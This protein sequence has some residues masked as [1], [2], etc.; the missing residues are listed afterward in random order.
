MYIA[1]ATINFVDFVVFCCG[2]AENLL[3]INSNNKKYVDYFVL[4]LQKGE[5]GTAPYNA[6][7]HTIVFFSKQWQYTCRSSTELENET[8]NV[9]IWDADAG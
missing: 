2:K 3:S 7:V 8:Q 1:L 9:E 4:Y 6:H 5:C